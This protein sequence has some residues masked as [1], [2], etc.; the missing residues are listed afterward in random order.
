MTPEIKRFIYHAEADPHL[1]FFL[2]DSDWSKVEA[3]TISEQSV[4][5]SQLGIVAYPSGEILHTFGLV[6]KRPKETFFM[7]G[8]VY[9]D[10]S[11][12]F[13]RKKLISKSKTV[14][15][16]H[17]PSISQEESSK[18]HYSTSLENLTSKKIR[19][20][21]FAPFLSNFF[22]H[23]NDKGLNSYSPLQF[24]EWF[25]VSNPD[26]WI[27]PGETVCDPD[28]YGEGR[29]FWAF[30]FEDEDGH[31]FIATAKLENNS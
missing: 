5:R 9:T 1:S 18:T 2:F 14:R 25:R 7:Q 16:F 22:G 19:V 31:T 28:N 13:N 4:S 17:G 30:F 24:K 15:I 8:P 23:I 12:V 26:G 20:T 6:R 3:N 10:S 21:K 27:A 29:G 11:P